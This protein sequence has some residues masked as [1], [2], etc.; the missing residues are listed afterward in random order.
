LFEIEKWRCGCSSFA[1]FILLIYRSC[2]VGLQVDRERL[3]DAVLSE[4]A[5]LRG[6][7]LWQREVDSAAVGMELPE[8]DVCDTVAGLVL[9]VEEAA[10]SFERRAAREEAERT[11]VVASLVEELVGQVEKLAA[12]P[13]GTDLWDGVPRSVVDHLRAVS[14]FLTNFSAVVVQPGTPAAAALAGSPDLLLGAMRADGPASPELASL[15]IWLLQLL[16]GS[17]SPAM[18]GCTAAIDE[19]TWPEALREALEASLIARARAIAVDR[20]ELG[21][22]G[23]A[24]RAFASGTGA[25]AASWEEDGGGEAGADGAGGESSAAASA[26]AA[27]K[28]NSAT[29]GKMSGADANTNSGGSGD[30][31]RWL[32]GMLESSLRG[33]MAV[34]EM[35]GC[36]EYAELGEEERWAALRALVEMLAE[37]EGG[38]I[39]AE[40]ER[41]QTLAR[42]FDRL[43]G[44]LES[45]AARALSLDMQQV[46]AARRGEGRYHGPGDGWSVRAALIERAFEERRPAGRQAG[47]HWF[48]R[49]GVV[50]R[51]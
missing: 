22:A 29:G 36:R 41:R 17:S 33:D 27:E 8:R 49:H 7:E 47:I 2:L 21:E 23:W 42:G 28:T 6:A 32:L 25:S 39:R 37:D 24:Q 5:T 45:E 50:L 11:V 26:A 4:A 35:L 16:R 31:D 48:L 14:D 13:Q 19:L 38:P 20:V 12:L 43:L 30:Y 3:S 9:R 40:L 15:H 1:I 51:V 46:C 34:V 44:R 18:V 10:L